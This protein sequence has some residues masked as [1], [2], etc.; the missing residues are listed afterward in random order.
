MPRRAQDSV[1][2]LPRPG[3][4]PGGGMG[5]AAQVTT[6]RFSENIGSGFVSPYDGGLIGIQ[7]KST[8]N[9]SGARWHHTSVHE[10]NFWQKYYATKVFEKAVRGDLCGSNH[11]RADPPP[12]RRLVEPPSPRAVRTG[13]G[14]RGVGTVDAAPRPPAVA[15][16]RGRLDGGPRGRLNGVAR[17]ADDGRS[18]RLSVPVRMGRRCGDRDVR[19]TSTSVA[20]RGALSPSGCRPRASPTRCGGASS[21]AP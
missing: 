2:L 8:G 11:M 17:A 13:R 9:M 10:S 20:P 21:C 6:H 4:G 18:R 3:V 7:R 5:W 12:R 16:A 19:G 14:G 15:V 1:D